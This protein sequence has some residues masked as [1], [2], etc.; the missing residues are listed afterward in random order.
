[1][2]CVKISERSIVYRTQYNPEN[3]PDQYWVELYLDMRNLE[4]DNL[5]PAAE[6]TKIKKY[7]RKMKKYV[8]NFDQIGYID[9][10]FREETFRKDF[11][12]LDRVRRADEV[13]KQKKKEE[14][15]SEGST[16]LGGSGGGTSGGY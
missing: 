1:M 6:I 7:T 5:K 13:E 15:M 9:S 2:G 11:G 16:I 4:L 8:D 14:G 10:T 12:F 3:F